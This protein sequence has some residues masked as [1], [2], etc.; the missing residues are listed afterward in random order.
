MLQDS[1]LPVLS[2]SFTLSFFFP[3]FLL[4]FVSFSLT[5]FLS[6]PPSIP[7]S[8]PSLSMKKLTFKIKC[9]VSAIAQKPAK[10]DKG[11]QAQPHVDFLQRGL[12]HS[13]AGTDC[14]HF[15][16]TGSPQPAPHRDQRTQL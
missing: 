5:F 2:F 7:L 12:V 15:S 4:F 8:L 6:L 9:F 11:V 3:F 1:L 13:P 16:P 10:A 14:A